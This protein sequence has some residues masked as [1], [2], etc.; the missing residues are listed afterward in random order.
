MYNFCEIIEVMSLRGS[1]KSLQ[2]ISNSL[3]FC[4]FPTTNYFLCWFN[5][6]TTWCSHNS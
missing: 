1:A 6:S 5:F 2:N 3:I 4:S